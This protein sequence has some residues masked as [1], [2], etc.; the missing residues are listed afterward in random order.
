[1]NAGDAGKGGNAVYGGCHPFAVTVLGCK[2]G[3]DTPD[4]GSMSGG[5]AVILTFPRVEEFLACVGGGAF[6]L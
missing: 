4:D 3:G 2:D 6:A 1:M 5:K